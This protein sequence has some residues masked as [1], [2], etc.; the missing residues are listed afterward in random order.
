MAK[1]VFHL[2]E[3]SQVVMWL[4]L[5]IKETRRIVSN[6]IYIEFN[7]PRLASCFGKFE[8]GWFSSIKN[9]PLNAPWA[10]P[11]DSLL[12]TYMLRSF[13]KLP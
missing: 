2:M 12:I 1:T 13:Q 9:N 6:L 3:I 7:S 10:C 5:I 4:N 8:N 11:E